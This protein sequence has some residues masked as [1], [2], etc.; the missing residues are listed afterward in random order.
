MWVK[1]DKET[2]ME[3]VKGLKPLESYTDPDGTLEMSCGQPQIDTIWGINNWPDLQQIVRCT[4]TK[5]DRHQLDW[6]TEYF[7]NQ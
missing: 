1:I 2:Y 3:K 7:E 4:H 6:D 5:K